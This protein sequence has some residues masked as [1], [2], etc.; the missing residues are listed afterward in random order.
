M[1][2][3]TLA[4]LLQ[5][6]D[7]PT[8]E[9]ILMAALQE[10]PI[11]GMPA[12]SF[13]VTDW[14]P[15]SLERTT[16]KM[17]ATGLLDR[18]NLIPTLTAAGFLD[19]AA[20]ITD[21]DGNLVEGWLELLAAQNYNNPRGAATFTQQRLVLTCTSGPGPYTRA[22][23]EIVAY[24]PSTGNRYRN[25]GSVTIPDGSSVTATF[26]S[27]SPGLGYNDAA[28]TI[29][30]LITPMPGVSVTNPVTV[31][32]VPTSTLTGTGTIAV[33]STTITTHPRSAKLTFTT[34]GRLDDSSA[35][36]TTTVYE[37]T[38][39]GF[40]GP[41]VA[42]PTCILD[43]L[44]LTL[45]DGPAGT[46]SFNAGD[47]W[48]V[49]IP[50]TPLLQAGADKESLDALAQGCRNQW[51]ALADVPTTGKFQAWVFACAKAQGLGITKC[52]TAPSTTVA[53]VENV[54]IAGSTA[55]ATPDQVT[56]EQSYIDE[57]MNLIGNAEVIAATA[58]PLVLGGTVQCRRGTTAAAKA[59]ADLAW[60]AYVAG[61]PI[62]GE[63][64]DSLIEI[65][66]LE[67]ILMDA[68]AHNVSDPTFGGVAAD[69]VLTAQECA[70]VADPP[71]T[72]SGLHWQEVA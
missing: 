27:E 30:G 15:G 57:R 34:G 55:T 4:D 53:G 52:K 54:Y 23:S 21:A 26:Q 9:A 14:I 39:V 6:R 1:P 61:A 42:G 62:G 35:Q 37:G 46:Q 19:L 33:S 71:S 36:A 10:A 22:D 24:S 18:E 43:D 16:L 67:Q 17:I 48:L 31:A 65:A 59:A 38:A 63:P 13:A 12:N 70:T 58:H 3:P 66:R 64:P 20:N 60:A 44:T 29:I 11:A 50:G 69:V 28:G 45:T 47:T 7:R 49:G 32:G 5:Q 8:I 51:P 68:G 2:T 40:S 72:S 25:V 41:F 56:A